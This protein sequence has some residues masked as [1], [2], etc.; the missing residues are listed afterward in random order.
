MKDLKK[1]AL[2]E[3][4]DLYLKEASQHCN[5]DSK[6]KKKKK[7]VKNKKN[8]QTMTGQPQE[9]YPQTEK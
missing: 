3:Y 4:Q 5:S 7:R 1:H 9:S 6:S 2:T 8:T